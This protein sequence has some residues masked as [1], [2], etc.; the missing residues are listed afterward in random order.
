VVLVLAGGAG[1]QLGGLAVERLDF[2][3]DG[4]VLVGD[5]AAGD[6]LWRSQI[7]QP[8]EYL[9]RSRCL[10]RNVGF[11]PGAGEDLIGGLGGGLAGGIEPES[12]P[13][14][15]VPERIVELFD[16]PAAVGRLAP[17]F[18]PIGY[19]A[20]LRGED[21]DEQGP[22]ADHG[23]HLGEVAAEDDVL[24]DDG[25]AGLEIRV[26]DRCGQLV[27][28]PELSYG[29]AGGVGGHVGAAID[30]HAAEQVTSHVDRLGQPFGEEL[31][32][33]GLARCLDAGHEDDGLTGLRAAGVLGSLW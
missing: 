8:S 19:G 3:A 23:G 20:G 21:Y 5:G 10:V 31:G 12:E 28:Q 17:I 7:S 1:W 32:D 29:F 24:D 11:G 9:S 13:G 14:C 30:D 26:A 27:A 6:L 22:A 16:G 4:E 18:L 25:E 33:G 15:L 2:L